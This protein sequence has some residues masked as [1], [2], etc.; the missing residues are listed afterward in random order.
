[1][2][3]KQNKES[4]TLKVVKVCIF[5]TITTLSLGFLALFTNHPLIFPSLG[6]TAFLL[7][8][9][10]MTKNASPKNTIL[11]HFIAV[12]CGYLSLVIFGLTN[13]S[14]TIIS[15][16]SIEFIM[17]ATLSLVLTFALTIFF[18]VEHPPAGATT[19]IVSLGILHSIS[20]VTILMI[21]VVILC[22][23]AWL[24]NN[25]FGIKYPRWNST[26]K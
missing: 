10:P 5:T 17:A 21:A 26:A 8:A 14:A 7:F 15:G 16:I 2:K 25:L 9:Y 6:P 23:E 24:L 4:T 22:A 20:D 12:V 11:G 19:L 18:S 13:T 1:M 3:K